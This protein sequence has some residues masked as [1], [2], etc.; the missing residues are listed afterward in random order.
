MVGGGDHGMVV[1]VVVGCLVGWCMEEPLP[2]AGERVRS[3]QLPVYYP[4][5]CA[6]S[7]S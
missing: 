6:S 5:P 3:A 2:V 1:V 7:S 4:V